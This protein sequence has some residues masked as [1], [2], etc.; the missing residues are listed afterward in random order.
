MIEWETNQNKYTIITSKK[1]YLKAYSSTWN[2]FRLHNTFCQTR[3]LHCVHETTML[4]SV[5]AQIYFCLFWICC[6]NDC[7]ANNTTV[8][9]VFLL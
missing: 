4:A 2:Y 3:G 6:C 7:N 5:I 9:C 8:V 1:N